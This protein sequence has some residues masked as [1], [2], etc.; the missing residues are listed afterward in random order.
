MSRLAATACVAVQVTRSFATAAE[1]AFDAWLD[2]WKNRMRVT[3]DAT[4][5]PSGCE[6]RLCREDVH[7]DYASR[8]EQ[9]W[10]GVPAGLAAN[11]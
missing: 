10:A 4:P 1:R 2:P 7:A 3:V 5:S 9:G 11:R 8:T 6:L